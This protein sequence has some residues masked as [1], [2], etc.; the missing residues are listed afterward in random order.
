MPAERRKMRFGRRRQGTK[1]TCNLGGRLANADAN[2]LGVMAPSVA[3]AQLGGKIGKFRPHFRKR[4]T[5]KAKSSLIVEISGVGVDV[6]ASTK[7]RCEAGFPI[8]SQRVAKNLGSYHDWNSVHKRQGDA[9]PRHM[10]LAGKP[11]SS[12][13]PQY[14]DMNRKPV[15]QA[16]ISPSLPWKDRE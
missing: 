9:I 13:V 11:L 2:A 4:S 14:T 8:P 5:A 3:D 16:P 1:P 15:A 10:R 6:A 7:N 12:F